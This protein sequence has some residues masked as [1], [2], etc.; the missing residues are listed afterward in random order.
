MNSV[1][2]MNN[3]YILA[4]GTTGNISVFEVDDGE[5]T[6]VS[7]IAFS[8]S[9]P[10]PKSAAGP[11][12]IAGAVMNQDSLVF[13]VAWLDGRVAICGISVNDSSSCSSEPEVEEEATA[14]VGTII[15]EEP[16]FV[17]PE[18]LLSLKRHDNFHW[19]V[20]NKLFTPDTLISIRSIDLNA[21]TSDGNSYYKSI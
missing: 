19:R 14:R 16:D 5:P 1:D 3:R 11:A 15:E 6:T 4:A 21:A 7:E 10:L 12:T 13:A 18:R 20:R 8:G 17:I 2:V 9:L